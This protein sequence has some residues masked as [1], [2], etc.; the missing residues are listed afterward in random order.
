MF[1]L[2]RNRTFALG[3]AATGLAFIGQNSLSIYLRPFLENVTGLDVN[4]LSMVLLGLG[5]GGLAGTVRRRL[6]PPAASHS[7]ADRTAGHARDP[8]PP[9]DRPRA[10]RRQSRL[11]C[12]SLWGFFTTPIPVAWNTWMAKIIPDE[13]EAA[14]DLQ[15]A[16]IQL[17]I[18]GGAFAGGVLFDTAGWWSAFLLAAVLL[19]GSAVLAALASRRT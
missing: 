19:T 4:T 14:A 3:M 9:A 13:L 10:V 15:V 8:C 17:A 7:R 18:A 6:R 16:L 2:L 5:L 12:W 11:S 1:G